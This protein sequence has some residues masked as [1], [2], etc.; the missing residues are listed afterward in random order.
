MD[1]EAAYTLFDLGLGPLASINTAVWHDMGSGYQTYEEVC[2]GSTP[3]GVLGA[4]MTAQAGVG[5]Y[6]EITY[7][8][9]TKLQTVVKVL[10]REDNRAGCYAD[11]RPPSNLPVWQV[12]WPG[13]RTS[14]SVPP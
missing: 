8:G 14:E 4:R 5:D 1:G 2:D 6:L 10:Y 11:R 7:N 12:Q 13:T 9:G 3:C